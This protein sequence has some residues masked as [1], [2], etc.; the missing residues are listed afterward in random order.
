MSKANQNEARALAGVKGENTHY[1]DCTPLLF[2][3]AEKSPGFFEPGSHSV[4]QA[5][6]E[7]T[8]WSGWPGTHADP[9]ASAS[10]KCA[11]HIQ[12]LTFLNFC[13]FFLL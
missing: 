11:H 13:P 7:F 8:V 12:G 5:V 6:L 10:Q 9:P 4:D 2:K 1:G 3:V